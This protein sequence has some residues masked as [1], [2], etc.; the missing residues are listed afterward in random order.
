[1]LKSLKKTK[2]LFSK[3]GLLGHSILHHILNLLNYESWGNMEYSI[4]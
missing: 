2:A 4:F 1:L 3:L